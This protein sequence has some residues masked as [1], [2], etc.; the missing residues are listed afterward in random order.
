[1]SGIEVDKKKL[2]KKSNVEIMGISNGS[3]PITFAHYHILCTQTL[4]G[5][6]LIL[7]N[8]IFRNQTDQNLMQLE[9]DLKSLVSH[10]CMYYYCMYTLCTHFNSQF[11]SNSFK[12][13]RYP[14][15]LYHVWSSGNE[16]V[17]FPSR[18]RNIL[19]LPQSLSNCADALKSLS[20]AVCPWFH[21]TKCWRL[22]PKASLWKYK[23]LRKF[24]G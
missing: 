18:N 4:C 2:I 13:P 1:M 3:K 14:L 7:L 5:L 12:F 19:K 16:T 9:P 11:H 23:Q 24:N 20:V 21:S 10:N 15:W 22:I 6:N 8:L 17:P